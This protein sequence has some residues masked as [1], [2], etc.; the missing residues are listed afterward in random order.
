MEGTVVAFDGLQKSRKIWQ[1]AKRWSMVSVTALIKGAKTNKF[2]KPQ[3]YQL[4]CDFRLKLI[5]G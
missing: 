3:V 4:L 2:A 1:P 5:C